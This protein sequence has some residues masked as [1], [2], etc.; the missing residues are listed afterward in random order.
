MKRLALLVLA[1]LLIS[2]AARAD[3]LY[4][5]GA[6]VDGNGI[7]DFFTVDGAAAYL[8]THTAGGWPLLPDNSI[9]T[10]KY[11][12]W[13]ADQSNG[14]QGGVLGAPYSYAFNFNWAGAALNTTFDFRWV[15]DDYLSDVR[16]NGVSLG[17]NNLGASAPWTIANQAIG[18]NGGV[19]SGLN[20]IEFIIWNTGG[21]APGYQGIS[22]PTGLAADFTVYGDATPVDPVPEP[23]TLALVALGAVGIVAR[24]RR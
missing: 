23:T 7:D 18:V 14:T 4:S 21:N 17:V 19:Q 15:S 11:I 16:L 9:T 1:S 6:D 12:S 24:R 20:T 13:A 5:T 3:L 2:P 8:V 10:G 22:G